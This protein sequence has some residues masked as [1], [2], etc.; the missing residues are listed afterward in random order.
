MPNCR[1]NC[2]LF[3]T[4][5]FYGHRSHTHRGD[6]LCH[7][8]ATIRSN[9]RLVNRGVFEIDLQSSQE[10]SAVAPGSGWKCASPLLTPGNA[11][12]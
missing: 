12:A 2:I 11:P 7:P 9:R 8:T 4:V 5:G 1:K 10:S 6:I 3:A